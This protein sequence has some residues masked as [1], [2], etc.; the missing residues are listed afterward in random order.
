MH[1]PDKKTM[2]SLYMTGRFGN[3]FRGWRSLDELQRSDYRG[4]VNMRYAD[5][6][7]GGRLAVKIDQDEIPH[8]L[9]QWMRGGADI[10][11][12]SFWEETP[13]AHVVMAG[14]IMCSPRHYELF[15]SYVKRA[16]REALVIAP[17]H[18][19]GIE[20]A[21]IVRH[22]M[23]G[24]SYMDL[25]ELFDDFPDSVVEFTIFDRLVGKA[26]RNTVFWEVRNY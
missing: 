8:I 20:A 16:K 13:Y 21:L 1:I 15:Y 10:R 6:A 18:A 17:R 11:R 14:E 26:G 3:Q 19:H 2:F 5:F 25:Q 4:K 7:G 23:D 9:A 12:V 24:S 22:M